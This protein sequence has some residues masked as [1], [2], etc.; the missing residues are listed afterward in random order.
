MN[1]EILTLQPIAAGEWRK[2]GAQSEIYLLAF[3][4]FILRVQHPLTAL[5]KIGLAGTIWTPPC[6]DQTDSV[7][8]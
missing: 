6:F 2:I 3:R 8:R 7:A 5:A 4:G 1:G